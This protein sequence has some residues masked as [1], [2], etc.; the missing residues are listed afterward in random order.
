MSAINTSLYAASP[1]SYSTTART[2][3]A[4]PSNE[5]EI[6]TDGGQSAKVT[7]SG[8]AVM[9]SRLFRTADPA[10]EPQVEVNKNK[11]SGSVWNF[12]TREDRTTLAKVYEYAG[13]NGIDPLKVDN[14]AFDLACYRH[15]EGVLGYSGCD[16]DLTGQP[17]T[18]SFKPADEAIA[19]RILTSKAINDTVIDQGYL[20]QA[21]DPGYSATHAVDFEF[22]Q[23]VVFAFSASGSDGA[24]DPNAKPVIRPKAA[25]FAPIRIEQPDDGKS[26]VQ[27][28]LFGLTRSGERVAP[29]VNSP[30]LG[31]L[32][33]MDKALLAG[34][35]HEA[36]R[37]GEGREGIE[38]VDKLALSLATQRWQQQMFSMLNDEGRKLKDSDNSPR[39]LQVSAFY[40]N[41]Q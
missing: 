17:V 1:Q 38:K 7:I 12:L 31:Y 8:R 25:D 26:L 24:A 23:Q 4:T 13:N 10:L 28:R 16:Y 14:L 20:R 33:D 19:Q 29:E 32:N 18:R 34:R 22:L 2:K 3:I 35:Y 36:L 40:L 5:G 27:E 39:L 37:R 6:S 41:D 9:L 21:L 15:S 30:L 11:P